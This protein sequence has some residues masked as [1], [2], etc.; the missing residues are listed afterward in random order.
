YI[1][2][3]SDTGSLNRLRGRWDYAVDLRINKLIRVGGR[4]NI[5]VFSEIYNLT[6]RKL[7]QPYPSGYT[8]QGYR[9]VT[10][11]VEYE[12]DSAPLLAKYL[13]TRD[14]NGD[15]V[16]TIDEAARGAI[17]NSFVTS[18]DNWRSWGAARQIR[19]GIEYT[20]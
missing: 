14:F 6:N 9:Y 20:F 7:P 18:T 5:S 19:T 10:G 12:W 15:G 1:P 4:K 11:G 8:F 2:Y 13:F 17:A 3:E 16:L